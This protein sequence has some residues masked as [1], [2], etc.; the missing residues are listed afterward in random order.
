MGESKA[1]HQQPE[2][3]EHIGAEAEEGKEPSPASP[4]QP[5][6]KF[7]GSPPKPEPDVKFQG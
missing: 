7:Q 6:V 1:A 2:E 3:E 4:E 5:D